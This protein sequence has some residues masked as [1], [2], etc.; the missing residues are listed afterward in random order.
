MKQKES[1]HP[2]S[3]T[4]DSFPTYL[5]GWIVVDSYKVFLCHR[6][7]INVDELPF[8]P[9]PPYNE[10]LRLFAPYRVEWV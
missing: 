7:N 4:G 8:N 6:K 3:A 1:C 9:A 5:L 2:A 10:T